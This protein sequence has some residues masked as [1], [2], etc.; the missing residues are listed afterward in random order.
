MDAVVNVS[1]TVREI[2]HAM[3][4]Q[5]FK[6]RCHDS[7]VA[8]RTLSNRAHHQVTKDEP[9][10]TTIQHERWGIKEGVVICHQLTTFVDPIRIARYEA[11]A[12]Q[13]HTYAAVG[14]RNNPVK[15]AGKDALMLVR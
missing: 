10:L 15:N 11:V 2:C 9:P 13:Q 4:K 3:D 8:G 7:F 12:G 5:F 6:D 14:F 1:K